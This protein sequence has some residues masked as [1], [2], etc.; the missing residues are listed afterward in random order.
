MECE[1][2]TKELLF[3]WK[4]IKIHLKTF[5]HKL[6]KYAIDYTWARQL[7]QTGKVI[8]ISAFVTAQIHYNQIACLG[9]FI[10][11][12]LLPVYCKYCIACKEILSSLE[13]HITIY[14]LQLF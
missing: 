11:S 4:L 14:L 10:N 12:E 6:L 9:E 1:Y 3:L 8:S 13:N 5:E 2:K 7:K